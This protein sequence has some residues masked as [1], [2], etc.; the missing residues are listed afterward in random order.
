M[1]ELIKKYRFVA[2]LLLLLLG[3]SG[4]FYA[5]TLALPPAYIHAWTQSDRW[6]LAFGFMD[7]GFKFWLPQTSNLATVSGVTGVDLPINEYVVAAIMSATGSDAPIIFRTYTLIFSLFGSLFFYAGVS[8]L[9]GSK[10]A[11]AAASIFA[12]TCPILVYYQAGFLPST[13][14]FAAALIGYY[15]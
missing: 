9:S 14:S 4:Y 2:A 13:T 10:M 3:L 12:F 5:Q 11:G 8:R 15:Y 6:A 7:N 1:L